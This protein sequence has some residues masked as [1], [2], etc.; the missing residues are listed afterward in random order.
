MR[1][2]LTTS[3]LAGLSSPAFAGPPSAEAPPAA[4]ELARSMRALL[5]AAMPTPLF[6]QSMNWG[7]QREVM[8]GVTWEKE[9]LLLKPNKQKKLKNDGVW[10]K[11]KMEAV[12]PDKRIML[13]VQ[14][15][16][17]PEK[18]R[19]TFDVVVTLATRITLEQQVWKN[20]VRLYSGETRARCR[21]ILFLKCESTTKVQ[22]TDSALPDVLFRM[23]VLNAKLTYDQF[24][25]EH[26]AGLGGEM[27][28]QL[29]DA[30]HGLIKQLRPSLEKDA[31]DK[32]SKAIV[33]AG[34]TK[35]VKLGL[36]KLF[37]GK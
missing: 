22:K 1:F 9:G 24:K 12:N 33:K 37:D 25:V 17:K 26:T 35:E 23:R 5:T 6:E 13:A 32:A 8:N 2:L 28:E 36:G 19:V 14:D 34:D 30:L 21:P 31:L 10:S 29:G 20:G 3:L 15:A 11:L 16:Q 4:D 18:G 7:H 27:A